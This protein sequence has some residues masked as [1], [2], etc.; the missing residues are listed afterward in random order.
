MG[1]L[2]VVGAAFLRPDLAP[3]PI[4]KFVWYLPNTVGNLL[5]KFFLCLTNM[6]IFFQDLTMFVGVGNGQIKITC[7]G[8]GRLDS[9]RGE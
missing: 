4:W 1:G 9:F 2:L 6:T 5:F 3:F 7:D 8:P